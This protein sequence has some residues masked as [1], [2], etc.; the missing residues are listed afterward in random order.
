MR[1]PKV[2]IETSVFNFVFARDAVDKR[3]DTLRLF[4]EIKQGRYLPYTS[5]YVVNELAEASDP[6][7]SEMLGLI[8]E[9]DVITLPVD[10]EAERLAALYVS[11]GII[12]QKYVVDGIHIA[13][14]TVYDL[15]FIVS[16]NFRH[17]F[18]DGGN[19]LWRLNPE[20]CGSC[21]LFGRSFTRK[22]NI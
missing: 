14:A 17:L 2:Y 12:P 5:G 22:Q 20:S 4:E 15:D 7:R 9:Y 1:V 21:M 11:E 8:V 13:I 6:K 3:D 19:R 18:T 16:F 10:A